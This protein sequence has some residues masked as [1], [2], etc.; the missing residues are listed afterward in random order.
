MCARNKHTHTHTHTYI[1]LDLSTFK[2]GYYIR[3][4]NNCV[5][6]LFW[7]FNYTIAEYLSHCDIS[8]AGHIPRSRHF[9][10]IFQFLYP[11]LSTVQVTYLIWEWKEP[12]SHFDIIIRASS[13]HENRTLLSHSSSPQIYDNLQ[14]LLFIRRAKWVRALQEF[15]TLNSEWNLL[16]QGAIKG[17]TLVSSS[18]TNELV[19]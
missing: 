11:C 18:F 9:L 4:K 19:I 10:L 5:I 7:F 12:A 14:L 1:Q 8:T 16:I 17:L 6:S 2:N 13:L 15:L 3:V